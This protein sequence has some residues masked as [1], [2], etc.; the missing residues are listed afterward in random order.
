MPLEERDPGPVHELPRRLAVHE[1]AH[2]H[3]REHHA[4][5]RLEPASPG[6]HRLGPHVLRLQ[7]RR[8]RVEA[9]EPEAGIAGQRLEGAHE[10][11]RF[12]RG[13]AGDVQRV[14]LPGERGQGFPQPSL[15]CDAELRKVEPGRPRRLG[16]QRARAAGLE[17]RRDPGGPELPVVR[18]Q[19]GG[20]E[21]LHGVGDEDGPKAAEPRVAERGVAGQRA[22]VGHDGAARRCASALRSADQDGLSCPSQRVQAA[23]DALHVAQGLD[24]RGDQ[25]GVRVGRGPLEHVAQADHRLVPDAQDDPQTHPAVGGHVAHGPGHR[26]ALRDDA[27]GAGDRLRR[28]RGAVRR[29]PVHVVH[30]PLDVR[31]EDGELVLQGNRPKLRLERLPLRP[32][33][34]EAARDD[35]GASDPG[36]PA[37]V[38][39]PNGDAGRHDDDGEVHTARQLQHRIQARPAPHLVVLRVDGVQLAPVAEVHEA[40]EHLGRP[41][42]SGLRR[43][44]HGDGPR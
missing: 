27:R 38:H 17:R 42:I 4:G 13:L 6:Q 15:R 36:L 44:D 5:L 16:E 34:G 3:R 23:G 32:G 39:H 8:E 28:R 30:E 41:G 2:G 21:H 35:H 9:H 40:P 31:T 12:H 1:R 22:G 37:V 10:H 11:L 29:H 25:L 19:H 26:P 14:V 33:L 20:L 7:A 18:E 43:A 24:V